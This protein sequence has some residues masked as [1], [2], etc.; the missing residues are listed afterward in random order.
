MIGA[1][2]GGGGAGA[3]A[4]RAHSLTDRKQILELSPAVTH[5]R[6]SLMASRK[7]LAHR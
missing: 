4:H 6:V 1:Q 2:D 3:P 5:Q 7:R